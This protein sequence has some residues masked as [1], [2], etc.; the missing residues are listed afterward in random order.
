MDADLEGPSAE[1][2]PES[3]VGRG[4]RLRSKTAPSD[5]AYEHV[6]PMGTRAQLR[7]RL[8]SNKDERAGEALLPGSGLRRGRRINR[9]INSAFSEWD[10]QKLRTFGALA[11]DG[12]LL[13][14]RFYAYLPYVRFWAYCR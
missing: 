7:S 1:E 4:K 14:S 5:T 2:G 6:V 8:R 13:G 12:H 10:L 11:L 3:C 9:S